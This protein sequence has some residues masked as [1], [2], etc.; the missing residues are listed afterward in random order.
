[1]YIAQL[2]WTSLSQP[3]LNPQEK[4][5][6]WSDGQECVRNDKQIQ[7]QRIVLYLNVICLIEHQTFNTEE[8]R[9]VR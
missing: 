5:G 2:P 7:T 6:S 3:P 8:N 1:M 4:S 9:E